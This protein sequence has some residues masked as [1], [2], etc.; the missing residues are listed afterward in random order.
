MLRTGL[1]GA[2]ALGVVL[3]QGCGPVEYLNQVSSRAASAML[4]AQRDGADRLAPYEYTKANEYYHKAREQ[5]GHSSYQ[6]AI[7]YGRKCEELATRARA[8]ARERQAQRAAS[9]MS[10]T[11]PAPAVAK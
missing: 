8:I 9:T 7:E 11:T 10:G 6:T 3:A 2:L 1:L 5:A 4:L